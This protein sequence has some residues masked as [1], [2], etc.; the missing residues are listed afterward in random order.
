M[1]KTLDNRVVGMAA[2]MILIVGMGFGRFAFTGLYP[3]MVDEHI[4]SI[5]GGSWAASANYAGYLVG[6]LALAK[7]QAKEAAAV[8]IAA[9][10]GTVLCLALLGFADA[11][12]LVIAVRALAGGL[13][14]A[15]MVAGSLWLLQHMGQ[16]HAAPALYAGVGIGIFLSA[17]LI[18]A[19]AAAGLTS[20]T[21][22]LGLAAVAALMTAFSCRVLQQSKRQPPAPA[23]VPTAGGGKSALNHPWQLIA[24]YGLAGLGYIITATYLP[25]L[26]GGALGGAAPLHIWAVF[27]LGAAPSCFLW[28]YLNRRLGTRKSL[29]LNLLVQGFG[30]LLPAL[31][32]TTGAYLVSAVLVGGTFMGTVTIA[33]PAAR[34]LNA[35]VGFN[36]LAVMTAVYGVGQIVGPLIANAIFDY[37]GS[38]AGSLVFAAA[39]LWLATV[40]CLPKFGGSE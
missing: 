5:A 18:A 4:L 7:L 29:L 27:G 39:A 40:L 11:L 14:A 6:A 36:M 19:G 1:A 12:W 9:L 20:Q 23:A 35:R 31:S 24:V 38:F 30:V 17:E 26:I 15:A 25:V 34:L 3:L 8:G 16:S 22:W 37:S 21:V 13:S 2:A 33:M 32:Q 10:V 28:H